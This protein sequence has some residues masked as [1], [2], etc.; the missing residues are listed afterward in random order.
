MKRSLLIMVIVMLLLSPFHP[1]LTLFTR[2][3]PSPRYTRR[4]AGREGT[5]RANA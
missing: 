4:A 2:S 1:S 5:D 3:H